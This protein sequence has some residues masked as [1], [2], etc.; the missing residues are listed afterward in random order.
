MSCVRNADSATPCLC[1]DISRVVCTKVVRY[2]PAVKG[3]NGKSLV[4]RGFIY[5]T[6]SIYGGCFIVMS[7]R[8]NIVG[9]TKIPIGRKSHPGKVDVG[10]FPA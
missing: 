6:T 10:G 8:V 2:S 7:G 5:G 9:L 3:G 1:W 4:D